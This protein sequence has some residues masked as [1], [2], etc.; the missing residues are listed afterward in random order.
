L[1]FMVEDIDHGDDFSLNQI[2]RRAFAAR[3]SIH[4][5]RG[6]RRRAIIANR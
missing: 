1:S 3:A 2:C 5:V 6:S 4:K